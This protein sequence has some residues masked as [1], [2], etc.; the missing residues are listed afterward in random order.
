[1]RAMKLHREEGGRQ[2]VSGMTFEIAEKMLCYRG[3]RIINQIT[4]NMQKVTVLAIQ[5]RGEK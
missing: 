4:A 1:M 5:K 3:C 2:A